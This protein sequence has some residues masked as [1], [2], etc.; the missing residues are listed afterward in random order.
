MSTDDKVKGHLVTR[1]TVA[2]KHQIR[3]EKMKRAARLFNRFL[4]AL[5]IQHFLLLLF[6]F[7]LFFFYFLLLLAFFEMCVLTCQKG[8]SI[9]R[10]CNLYEKHRRIKKRKKSKETMR[11]SDIT[12]AA[13][14]NKYGRAKRK[15]FS[16][17]QWIKWKKSHLLLILCLVSVRRS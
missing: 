13:P 6:L 9:S 7:C 8:R 17:I 2:K 4:R 3:A 11:L 15:T 10:M 16:C 5:N 12:Y 14:E 1:P